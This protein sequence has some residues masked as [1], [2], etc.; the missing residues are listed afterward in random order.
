LGSYYHC[1]NG[2]IFTGYA[3]KCGVDVTQYID[4]HNVTGYLGDGSIGGVNRAVY[5]LT[6]IKC[7]CGGYSWS[8]KKSDF[9]PKPQW[10]ALGMV[11][12]RAVGAFR[13]P[14]SPGCADSTW[15]DKAGEFCA[16]AAGMIT[17]VR[18]SGAVCLATAARVAGKA[19]SF[20]FAV[21]S[22]RFFLNTLYIVLTGR[23]LESDTSLARAAVAPW[24]TWARGVG[25]YNIRKAM[26]EPL[27]RDLQVLVGMV[28]A[29]R[30]YPWVEERS[31]SVVHVEND[32]TLVQ[33]G[34]RVSLPLG[35]IAALPDWLRQLFTGD[36]LIFGMTLPAVVGSRE[37]D[38][39]SILGANTG[40]TELAG[41]LITAQTVDG[42]P[43]LRRHF[44]N[45]RVTFWMDNMEDVLL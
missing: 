13:V 28:Q 38:F 29:D 4:D 9:T 18:S 15:P 1:R 20:S 27:I 22:I 10:L 30:V 24:W 33:N 16:L 41:M 44:E 8:N 32:T 23:P 45:R 31:I 36:A 11:V 21:P 6:Y 3:R 14:G 17:L 39:T 26:V 7:F 43:A 2:F 19:I 42:V 25:M 34:A 40:T 35:D 5:C 12:D 37:A